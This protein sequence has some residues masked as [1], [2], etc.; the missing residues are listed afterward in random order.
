MNLINCDD[1]RKFITSKCTLHSIAG[2]ET[3]SDILASNVYKYGDTGVDAAE[4]NNYLHLYASSDYSVN[5]PFSMTFEPMEELYLIII[6]SGG[7][8]RLSYDGSAYLSVTSDVVLIMP[9]SK[10]F[11]LSA[12][13]IPW[14]FSSFWINANIASDLGRPLG[15][16]DIL[17]RASERSIQYE[18]MRE[19]THIPVCPT[20]GALLSMHS[21]ITG[22]LCSTYGNQLS[23]QQS[24]QGTPM[25]AY[26]L[27]LRD[28]IENNYAG[29]FSLSAFELQFDVNR[30]RLCREFSSAFGE[31][32]MQYLKNIRIMKA[33]E[34]LVQSHLNIQEIS[35]LVG[36][37]NVNNFIN[38][39]RKQTGT[40]PG[41]FRRQYT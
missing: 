36:Y 23:A 15:Q 35:S 27:S 8:G 7:G 22:F 4:L 3:S 34:M 17:F 5:F 39:F 16:S 32:P 11:T 1:F 9:C 25:P 33:K 41:A 29:N 19:L 24:S 13:L 18:P 37:D 38:N 31:P 6:T 12:F 10:A 30:F 21:I 20:G 2:V 40:T 28:L 26:L 14:T